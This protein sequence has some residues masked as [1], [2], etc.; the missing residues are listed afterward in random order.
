MTLIDTMCKLTAVA[1]VDALA[2]KLAEVEA[3]TLIGTLVN[4][5]SVTVIQAVAD[6]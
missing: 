6:R 2:S 1:L 3:E 4:E 5:K